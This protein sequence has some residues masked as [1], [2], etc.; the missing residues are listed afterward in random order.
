MK[1]GLNKIMRNIT[2]TSAK[3]D[4]EKVIIRSIKEVRG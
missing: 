4:F 1:G 3:S 2:A